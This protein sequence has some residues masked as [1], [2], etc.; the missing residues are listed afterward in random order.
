M[1]DIFRVTKDANGQPV[2]THNNEVLSKDVF[3][4]R[5]QASKDEMNAMKNSVTPGIDDDPDIMAMKAR[6]QAMKKPI[7]KAK[8]GSISLKASKIST[9]QRNP[10]HSSW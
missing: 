5:N 10:K 9:H 2:Y 7:K 8:G 4:Q 3:D 6:A 1:D